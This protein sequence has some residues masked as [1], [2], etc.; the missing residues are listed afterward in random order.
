MS[1]RCVNVGIEKSTDSDDRLLTIWSSEAG[2][3]EETNCGSEE[4]AGI[5]TSALSFLPA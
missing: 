3:S 1:E 5:T 4:P 2:V